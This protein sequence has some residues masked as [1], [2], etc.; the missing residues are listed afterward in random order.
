MQ[1][2]QAGMAK[3]KE[4]FLSEL[5]ETAR[6]LDAMLDQLYDDADVNELL[7]AIR[8]QAHKLY[9]RA[10]SF[11]LDL[12]AKLAAELEAEAIETAGSSASICTERVEALLVALLD[13]I[14]AA[15]EA[16]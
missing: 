4:R 5:P 9:G 14:D 8:F 13:Q 16:H 12:V 1:V 3:L 15:L 6:L 7:G 10:A 11:G 2:L